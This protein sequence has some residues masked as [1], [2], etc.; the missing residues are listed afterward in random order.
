MLPQDC[1]P[2]IIILKDSEFVIPS[3]LPEGSTFKYYS[4]IDEVPGEVYEDFSLLVIDVYNLKQGKLKEL[5]DRT[6]M[7][8]VVFGYSGKKYQNTLVVNVAEG[9]GPFPNTIEAD[10]L[11]GAAFFI[12][13]SSLERIRNSYSREKSLC[14]ILCVFGGT[15]PANLSGRMVEYVNELN[16]NYNF[17][18][19][20][21]SS[22]LREQILPANVSVSGPHN[23]L[24]S[25]FCS[26]DLII[27]SPGNIYFEAMIV[28]APVIA[29]TQSEK[30]ELDFKGYP[31][32]YKVEEM[33]NCL[34]SLNEIYSKVYDSKDGIRPGS[35]LQKIINYINLNCQ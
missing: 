29:I 4:S 15:D 24:P 9:G 5:R 17:S 26:Y 22:S 33:K 31:W 21:N 23:N 12:C 3:I 25:I 13:N 8:I 18:I 34:S 2:F 11:E 30:Q 1:M 28:G 14:K 27:T 16:L 10:I 32:I 7:P 19:I 35:G 20:S 6:I